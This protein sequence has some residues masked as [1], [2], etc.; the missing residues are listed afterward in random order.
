MSQS[1]IIERSSHARIVKIPD[2]SH[3]LDAVQLNQ[4]ELSFRRW[5]E[6][7][8]RADINLSR[9]RILLIFL[10]IR[11]TGAK[12]SEILA[13]N[14]FQ[15]ID[16]KRQLV[17]LGKRS[18][19]IERL[20]REVQI[21][22]SLSEELKTSLN[23]PFF[24]K[25]LQNMFQ[26]DP[27]H[28]RR[29]FYERALDCG[30]PPAM[31]APE[32]IRKSRAVEMI[33]SNVPLPVVQ[34]I[35]GHST[36]NIT[37]SYVAFSDDDI[38]KVAKYFVEKESRRKTSARNSFFGKI[39]SIQKG[40]IQTK[41]EMITVGG[42]LVTTLI[43]NDSLSRLGLKTG[44]LVAAEVKA[45]WVIL[46]KCDKEPEST[47]ENRFFGTIT[48]ISKG[49]VTTEYVVRIPDGTEL[50]SIVSSENARKTGFKENDQVW[51]IFNSFSVVLH[52]D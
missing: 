42:D 1:S 39:R 25:Y 21:P 14:P 27:G 26:V 13:L 24:N 36:L 45:P 20:S 12:L 46:Q 22:D 40:D 44:S 49:K 7:S 11:Y 52:T 38:Q 5:A 8:Q 47:A 9:R 15:H 31:G 16:F 50:C 35:L 32:V 43:T 6:G 2:Q 37:S 17:L 33:Q 28:V 19:K 18:S 3:C 30:F 29:K 41:V 4:L 34:R 51:V 23:E 48:R 10:L